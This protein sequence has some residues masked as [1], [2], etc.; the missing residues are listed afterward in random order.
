VWEIN[1]IEVEE[2]AQKEGQL[3]KFE[4]FRKLMLT[5]K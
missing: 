5:K 2:W 1:L 4:H 3:E